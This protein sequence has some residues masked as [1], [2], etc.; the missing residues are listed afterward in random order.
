MPNWCSINRCLWPE[1]VPE[2]MWRWLH[3]LEA[4]GGLTDR[5]EK[6]DDLLKPLLCYVWLDFEGNPRPE[7]APRL[8]ECECFEPMLPEEIADM[9]FERALQERSRRVDGFEE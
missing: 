3:F 1:G 8:I 4:T 5:D 9:E 2:T 6:L 7:D